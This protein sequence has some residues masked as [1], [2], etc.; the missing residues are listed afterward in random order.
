MTEPTTSTQLTCT[1]ERADVEPTCPKCGHY[2]AMLIDYD[3]PYE[4]GVDKRKCR[5]C[6]TKAVRV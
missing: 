1:S 6:G 5:D 2:N 3:E 4:A